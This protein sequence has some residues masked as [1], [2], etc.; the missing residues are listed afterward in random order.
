VRSKDPFHFNFATSPKPFS[1]PMLPR[2][3][4]LLTNNFFDRNNLNS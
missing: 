4:D 1:R 3:S 2:S